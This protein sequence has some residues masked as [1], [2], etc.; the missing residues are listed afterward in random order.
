MLGVKQ[1]ALAAELGEDWSQK[2][3]SVLEQKEE[4]EPHILEQVA[5]ILQV[6]PDAIKNFNEEAAITF[7]GN[8]V[9]NH[10]NAAGN[11]LFMYYPTFNPIEKIVQLY[12]EKIALLERLLE[13]EREKTKLMK[14]K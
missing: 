9:N 12:D 4:L 3:V 11:S 10:D 8:T 2:R 5:K 1:E 7:I 6:P 14:E 13:S